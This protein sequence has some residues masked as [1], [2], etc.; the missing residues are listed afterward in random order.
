MFL[1]PS[2]LAAGRVFDIALH[3]QFAAPTRCHSIILSVT[4]WAIQFWVGSKN[5]GIHCARSARRS[6]RGKALRARHGIG[7]SVLQRAEKPG[8][9]YALFSHQHAVFG[10][11][12]RGNMQ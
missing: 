3:V 8:N 6:Q 9:T 11:S 12:G 4:L 5:A 2:T 1:L 10:Q 7:G